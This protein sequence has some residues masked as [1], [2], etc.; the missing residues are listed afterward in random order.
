LVTALG[1]FECINRVSGYALAS[2]IASVVLFGY[3]I[4]HD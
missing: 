4:V 2:G 3:C 1:M